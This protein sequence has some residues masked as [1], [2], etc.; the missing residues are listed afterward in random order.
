MKH[1]LLSFFLFLFFLSPAFG[2]EAAWLAGAAA[3]D[4]TPDYP[5]RLSGYGARKTESEGIAQKIWAKALAI[6]SDSNA[7]TALIITLDNC[8]VPASFR[9]ELASRLSKRGIASSGFALCSTHTHSAPSIAGMLPNLFASPISEK[10]QATIDRYTKELLERLEQVAGEAISKLAPAGLS[11][12][13]GNVDFA[14]NRRTSGGPVHHNMPLLQVKGTD[15]KLIA[16]LAN[17]ACHCTTLGGEWN[18]IHGDWAGIAQEE[19]EKEHPGAVAMIAIGCGADSNPLPR[20][21]LDF[22]KQYGSQITKE[23]SRLVK[24]NAF[25]ALMEPLSFKISTIDLPFEK[26]PTKEQWEERAKQSGI[27]G[28]HA[29]RNLERLANGDNIPESLPY[30]IQVWNFGDQLSMIFLPGEVVV[31]YVLRLKNELDGERLW[32]NA[33]ANAVPCYIPSK[34]ILKEGGYEAETSLWYYDQ[35]ARLAPATE[36]LI[37]EKTKELV[38]PAFKQ[39]KAD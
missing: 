4:I 14:K 34:R 22:A 27:V 11:W 35:P 18:Q 17:Y 26:L 9:A 31:D 21:N 13:E 32:V 20:G 30:L 23:T 1:R 16:L 37:I 8:G 36:D 7:P 5:I 38:G 24:Q 19:I 2:A 25:T 3:V 33:Y 6:K 15:G 28:Y 39:E 29:K 10:E 12:G